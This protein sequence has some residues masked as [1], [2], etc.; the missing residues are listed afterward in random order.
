M[1]ANIL[2]LLVPLSIAWF[3]VLLRKAFEMERDR[4]FQRMWG[5]I[6][7]SL[8]PFG[9]SALVW[10]YQGDVSVFGRSLLLGILGAALGAAAMIWIGYFLAPV[11]PQAAAVSVV[12]PSIASTP[13]TPTPQTPLSAE[14]QQRQRRQQ[15]LKTR[16]ELELSA[17][18]ADGTPIRIEFGQVGVE[19]LHIKDG[20]EEYTL[21][22]SIAGPMAAFVFSGSGSAKVF[23]LSKSAKRGQSVDIRQ[24]RFSK[25][26]DTIQIG[27]HAF[28][29][30]T[31]G[32]ILQLIVVGVLWYREGDDVDEI[33]FKYKIHDAGSF[34]IDAL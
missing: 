28:I 13:P 9:V 29:E 11:P 16:G 19:T 18:D 17:R 15:L 21:S 1:T 33:R 31:N 20:G 30:L 5:I 24:I 23:H 32:K 26:G 25:G 8:I 22:V 7:W 2:Y 34:L 6:A 14:E 12:A 3:G 4:R 27:Q 10:V